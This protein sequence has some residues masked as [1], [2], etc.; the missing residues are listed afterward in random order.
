ML[1]T[2]SLFCSKN[3]SWDPLL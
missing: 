1:F 3:N 2:A